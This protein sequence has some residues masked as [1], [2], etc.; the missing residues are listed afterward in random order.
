[1]FPPQ[2]HEMSDKQEV[3]ID[4]LT[5]GLSGSLGGMAAIALIYPLDQVRT[6]LQAKLRRE[7]A[8]T[9]DGEEARTGLA[10]MLTKVLS[11]TFVDPV[12]TLHKLV[13]EGRKDALEDARARGLSESEVGPLA[14]FGNLYRGL[15]ATV[16]SVG[17][18][19][20]LYFFLYHQ[21]K[22]RFES[23][24]RVIGRVENLCIAIVAG[25]INATLTAPLWTVTMVLKLEKGKA[26]AGVGVGGASKGAKDDN[27]QAASARAQE[28]AAAAAAEARTPSGRFSA[29]PMP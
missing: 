28:A 19:N 17:V 20:A 22:K 13:L 14:G 12:A 26:G 1:M 25:A 6:V 21:F 7:A 16:F 27:P 9:V 15:G 3:E 11:H 29:L 8:A 23:G 4:A 18:S 24:G 2:T 10:G 5:H